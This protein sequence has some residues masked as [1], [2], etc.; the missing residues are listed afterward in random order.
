MEHNTTLPTSYKNNN[1][2]NQSHFDSGTYEFNKIV[3]NWNMRDIMYPK[4]LSS[5]PA[6]YSFK[7]EQN[8][9]YNNRIY[10]KYYES[11]KPHILEEAR[12]VITTGFEDLKN[13]KLEEFTLKFQNIRLAENF[14]NPSIVKAKGKLP[15][16]TEGRSCLSIIIFIGEI[17][18]LAIGSEEGIDTGNLK[19]KFIANEDILNHKKFDINQT[20]HAYVLGSLVS[21][22]RMYE[23][24]TLKPRVVFLQDLIFGNLPPWV[25]PKI[26]SAQNISRT[27]PRS[28]LKTVI[29]SKS[30]A[31]IVKNPV[32]IFIIGLLP[33]L[34]IKSLWKMSIAIINYIRSR[35][36][37]RASNQTIDKI[38]EHVQKKEPLSDESQEVLVHKTNTQINNH[39]TIKTQQEDSI[40]SYDG[41]LEKPHEKAETA[42]KESQITTIR[43]L[44]DQ[45]NINEAFRAFNHI[46]QTI[47]QKFLDADNGLYL[48]QGPPGTGKTTTIA[49]ILKALADTEKRIMLCAPSNKA[50]QVIANRFLDKYPNV[51]MAF[52]GVEKKLTENLREIFIH[53]WNLFIADQIE[54]YKN[55]LLSQLNIKQLLNL[56]LIDKPEAFKNNFLTKLTNISDIAITLITNKVSLRAP[57]CYHRI[58][59]DVISLVD[60]IKQYKEKLEIFINKVEEDE[61]RLIKNYYLSI[62]KK[63][64]ENQQN[65]IIKPSLIENCENSLHKIK[66]LLESIIEV[67]ELSN[68]ELEMLNSAKVIFCTLSVAGRSMM[69]EV[70]DI[71]V[72][73]ID[74]AGQTV[75]AETLI[76]FSLNPKKCLLVGDVNQLPATVLSKEAEKNNFG[77]S[78]MW[79]LLNECKQLYE[80]LTLQYRM[81]SQIRQ[82]PSNQFYNGMLVDGENIATREI[83]YKTHNSFLFSPYAFINI[84]GSEEQT[85][86]S[87]INRKEALAIIAT[88]KYLKQQVNMPVHQHIGVISFYAGQVDLLKRLIK[89]ENLGDIRIHT[90]D[91]FQGDENDII[92]ISFVRANYNANVGFL[93]DFRRLN[94]AITRP[95]HSLLMFGNLPTLEK[96]TNSD[97]AQLIADVKQRNALYNEQQ[98]NEIT[99]VLQTVKTNS[100]E[101]VS[102]VTLNNNNQI[103]KQTPANLLAKKPIPKKTKPKNSGAAKGFFN[104]NNQ[105]DKNN[106]QPEDT[107]TNSNKTHNTN[108]NKSLKK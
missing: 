99:Q 24:C 43:K 103:Y 33:F 106:K 19:I 83:P 38:L 73:I 93:R 87:F 42:T 75:E 48:L 37:R 91:G 3:L 31:V 4:K 80:I 67:L 66:L 96:A 16:E 12:T 105:Q 81:H 59:K 97:V 34:L 88:I 60:G 5:L 26:V 84:G 46:Q 107:L 65:F 7:Y 22:Q 54:H 64:R 53:G 63:A 27:L 76:P 41:I 85:G 108:Q 44:N 18:F 82:W 58:Y 55:N 101:N 30:D 69:R 2:T 13:K 100:V 68:L 57:N 1:R 72:L 10:D 78:M 28:S 36:N 50:V 94:V 35:N 61:L 8:H 39:E 23:V 90:V 95:K 86:Y 17:F 62:N 79:R 89:K 51:V 98:F 11:F 20:G 70:R 77:W 74:E 102:A 21:H 92:L 9:Y 104:G 49:G 52:A 71:D 14:D 45:V 6:K 32:N 47:A 25:K 40:K 29:T 56:N 15:K